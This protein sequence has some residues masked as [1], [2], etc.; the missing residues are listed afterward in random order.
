V[1]VRTEPAALKTPK[2]GGGVAQV[3]PRRDRAA[4]TVPDTFGAEAARKA[5]TLP[6]VDPKH[7]AAYAHF[8]QLLGAVIDGG[9]WTRLDGVPQTWKQRQLL[10][11]P[12][13]FGPLAMDPAKGKISP[14]SVEE[15]AIGLAAESAGV[16]PGPITREAT[17]QAEFVD[18]TGNFWDVKSPVSPWGGARWKF[19][20]PH[21]VEKVRHDIS[22]D[23]SVLLNLTRLS[24]SDRTLLLDTLREQLTSAEIARVVV[25]TTPEVFTRE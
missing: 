16:V 23:N 21:Q 10:D 18:G 13:R 24:D 3:N 4:A 5:E 11:V 25:V 9:A 17:G 20:A 1:K 15:A 22:Q 19:D 12:A 7:V 6:G 14:G 8:A 2:V